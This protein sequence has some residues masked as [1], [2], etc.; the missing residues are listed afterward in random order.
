MSVGDSG[1]S[2]S[3]GNVEHE[4]A[5]FTLSLGEREIITLTLSQRE[6]AILLFPSPEVL[7]RRSRV[8]TVI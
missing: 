3:S 6:R 2:K 4:V 8:M 1:T 7:R 5:K